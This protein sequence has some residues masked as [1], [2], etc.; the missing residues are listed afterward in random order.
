MG[1]IAGSAVA[2]GAPRSPVAGNAGD[3]GARDAEPSDAGSL[4]R[5]LQRNEQLRVEL[6]AANAAND[7]LRRA[8]DELRRTMGAA[9]TEDAPVPRRDMVAAR[10]IAQGRLREARD[11]ARGRLEANPNDADAH[12]VLSQ[13]YARASGKGATPEER[14]VLWL[15]IHHL[16]IAMKSGA[17]GY[18]V[19]RRLLEDYES[20]TPTAEDFKARGWVDGQRLRVSFAPFEWIDEETTIRPRKE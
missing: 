4:Q 2:V 15:A 5:L 1:A 16:T 12:M 7:S 13:V 17:I 6:A 3:R 10:L 8:N 18:D 11:L 14:A 20:R 19:G 9:R